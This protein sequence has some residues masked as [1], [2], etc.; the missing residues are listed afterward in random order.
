[1]A[2]QVEIKIEGDLEALWRLTQDPA[3]HQ[4]WDLRFTKIEYLPREPDQPQKF[5]Y[6]TRLGFAL[7]IRGEGETIQETEKGTGCRISSLRF[8]SNQRLSLIEEGSGYW[9]YSADGTGV[10][11]KT[12]YDYRTRY[13]RR[14]DRNVFRPLMAWATAWSFDRLRLWIEKGIP[15]EVSLERTALHALARFSLA[16][17]WL[18]HGIVPKLAAMDKSELA[19]N[20]ALGFS[21]PQSILF[22][23]SAGIAEVILGFTT[24]ICWRWRSLFLLQAFLLTAL[25][26]GTLLTSPAMFTQAFNPFSTT[27]AMVALCLT[28]YVAGRELPSASRCR[29]SWR[30]AR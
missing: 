29:W 3:L 17:I 27:L 10:L 21:Q 5:L 13:G 1:M 15:P 20:A 4:R 16:A 7:R 19:M 22:A 2:I 12:G 18:Y 9:R 24:L 25:A 26:L 6:E 30:S 11:F 28:G 23:R 14:F 8:W